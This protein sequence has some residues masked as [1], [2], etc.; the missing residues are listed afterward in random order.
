MISKESTILFGHDVG[1]ELL[2]SVGKRLSTVCRRSDLIARMGG[3][4]FVYVPPS[5]GKKGSREAERESIKPL[6][7]PFLSREEGN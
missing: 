6:K 7:T 4:E 5:T 3:D 1:D 2:K